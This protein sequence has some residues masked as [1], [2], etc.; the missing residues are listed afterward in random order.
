M[1]EAQGNLW[2]T[3]DSG[4]RSDRPERLDEDRARQLERKESGSDG[5]HREH[6]GGSG[7]NRAYQPRGA[8][9]G[10]ARRTTRGAHRNVGLVVDLQLRRATGRAERDREVH[11]VTSNPHG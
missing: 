2:W 6:G 11:P 9:R 1:V 8:T 4:N 5:D 7:G 3:D 10:G